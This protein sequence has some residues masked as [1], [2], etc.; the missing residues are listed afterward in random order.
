[1]GRGGGGAGTAVCPIPRGWLKS[2][3]QGLTDRQFFDDFKC[4]DKT[5]YDR[6]RTV[7][8][9]TVRDAAGML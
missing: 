4:V 9:C 2:Q 7:W 5:A 3:V 6:W 8:V 1:V